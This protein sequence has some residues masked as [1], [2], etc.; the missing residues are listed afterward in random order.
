ML[1]FLSIFLALYLLAGL[2]LYIKQRDILYF[3]TTE[4]QT[5]NAEV[6]W[7]KTSTGKLKIW[8]F[9]QGNPAIIYFGGNSEQVEDNIVDFKNMFRD[10]SVY[11]VNY[12]GYGGSSGS[13]TEK[14]L[15][16]DAL[17]IYDQISPQHSSVSVIG[18]SLGSGVASYLAA[19]REIFRLVLITPYDSIRNVAQSHYP[20]FPVKWLIKDRF[21][22]IIYA[23]LIKSKILVLYAEFDQMVPWAH[24]K[25]LLNFLPDATSQLI[26]GATH[27]DIT[28]NPQYQKLLT[29]FI[30]STE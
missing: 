20:L 12:R 3:P 24:T 19:H 23:P 22:S 30:N 16:Q 26:E 17:E 8:K 4:N 7:L 14:G 25:N 15:F 28:V 27:N 5:A 6:L 29:E 18:R 11:V 13:P 9:H 10:F 21:D 2:F 1:Q